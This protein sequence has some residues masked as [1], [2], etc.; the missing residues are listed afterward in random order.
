MPMKELRIEAR[1]GN[2]DAVT[3]FVNEALEG[4]DCPVRARLQIDVAI[5]ELFSN[6]ANYAYPLGEG[7]AV[8]RVEEGKESRAALITF[9]DW[10]TPFDPLSRP[11]PDTTLPA[12]ER[13]IG[14]LGIFMVRKSMD[15]VQYEYKDRHNILTVRKYF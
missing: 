11:D 6:I 5:D 1:V 14:G 15:D 13:E 12:E 10:G 8:V 4:M 7:A 9:M 3:D 2:I